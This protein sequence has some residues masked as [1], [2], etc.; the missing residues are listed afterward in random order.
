L[1]LKPLIIGDLE[2]KVPIV[3]GAM[4]VKISTSSLV[5]SV[6]NLNAAGTLSSIALAYDTEENEKNY[7]QASNK[8]LIKEI[9]STKTLTKN[10]FGCNILFALSNYEELVINSVKAKVDFIV[11]GAGLPLDLP[12]LVYMN[13]VK[14]IPIVSS[15]KA[16]NI[17]IKKWLK[18][19]NKLPDA[20]IVEGPLAG[21][22]LG[23]SLE[24]LKA[25]SH[26]SLKE[27]TKDVIS[28]CDEI[29]KTK[30]KKIPVIAAGGVFSGKDI[31]EFLSIGAAGVQI[32][33]RFVLTKECTVS[34][35]F[36]EC[37]INAS[38]DDVSFIKSPVGMPGRVIN[39]KFSEEVN[40]GINK[41]FT[42]H[43]KCLKTCNPSTAPFC[44][45]NALF[46]AYKGDIDN[47][48]IFAGHNVYK[49]NKLT[50]SYDL[51]NELVEES[52]FELNKITNESKN[53]YL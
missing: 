30:F 46:N 6:S 42:C 4:G 10:P 5:S 26:K 1:K 7:I 51:I 40:K 34:D 24:N 48:I 14:L 18:T 41:P 37:Y 49:L 20:V 44:I 2:F 52:I 27:I 35:R 15:A 39:T 17:I 45:A 9:T 47:S 8:A 29:E 32:A 38:E 36:K 21:G 33:T 3:Q 22:H 53:I 11:S 50:T 23:F 12:K 19:Y 43:Y 31:A 25:K 16:L 13:D 28:L